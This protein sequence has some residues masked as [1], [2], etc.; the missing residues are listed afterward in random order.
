MGFLKKAIEFIVRPTHTRTIL[1]L[2]ILAAA[3]PLTVFIVQQQQQLRQRA[4]S[5]EEKAAC[6]AIDTLPTCE[7]GTVANGSCD[8]TIKGCTIGRTIFKCDVEKK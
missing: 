3:I 6:L 7:P 1:V 2:L 4:E 5:P 8:G